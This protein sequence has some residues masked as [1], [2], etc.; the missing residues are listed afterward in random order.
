MHSVQIGVQRKCY[1]WNNLLTVIEVVV[2]ECVCVSKQRVC[3]CDIVKLIV[4]SAIGIE[5][6]IVNEFMT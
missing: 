6:D 3:M 1:E 4:G 5:L 2:R